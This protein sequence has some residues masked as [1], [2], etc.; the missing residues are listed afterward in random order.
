MKDRTGRRR[1]LSVAS[2]SIA[3][4]IAALGFASGAI[5]APYPERPITLIVPYA[6]GGPT[7]QHLRVLAEEAG[8][9]LGQPVLVDARPGSNGIHGAAAMPRAKADGYLLAVLPASV[10]REPHINKVG[11]DPATS[12]SYVL[13]LSDYSF[14]LTVRADAPWKNWQEFAA[15]AARRPGRINVG[16]TGAAGTPRIVM[17]EVAAKTGLQFNMVPYKGDADVATAILGG[18][19]DAAPLTGVA[20]PHIEAGKMRYL[21]MLTAERVARYPALPTLR[22]E[23]V[24]AHIDSPYGIVGP[25]GMAPDV[26]QRLH[27]AFRQALDTPAGRRVLEQLNQPKNYMDPAAYRA[28]A[29]A[30]F[31]RERGRVAALRKAGLLE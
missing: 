6:P 8:K 2:A 22:E 25:A 31:E 14:G 4:A 18:H 11:Y 24:D 10:Y 20:V 9:I 27:D 30:A 1:L 17:D 16:A 7:D 21:T 3:I 28:Y 19:I 5:A 15:D 29:L 13:M 26:V 23:G 12:F